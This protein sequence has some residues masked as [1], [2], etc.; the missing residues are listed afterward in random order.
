MPRRAFQSQGFALDKVSFLRKR[1]RVGVELST[2][3]EVWPVSLTDRWEF[4]SLF[5][6]VGL[7]EGTCG[8]RFHAPG[9]QGSGVVKQ[10][11]LY[12]ST[13]TLVEADR[14]IGFKQSQ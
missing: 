10:A 13:H 8:R 2:S 11:C 3:R 5:L 7:D 12:V 14:E 1:D 4:L 9:L 6:I